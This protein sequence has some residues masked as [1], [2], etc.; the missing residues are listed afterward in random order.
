MKK[1]LILL[2]ILTAG[3]AIFEQKIGSLNNSISQIPV[4]TPTP[5]L[6]SRVPSADGLKNL[7]MKY[8]NLE[9]GSIVYSFYAIDKNGRNSLLIYSKAVAKGSMA[10]PA[11]SWSPGN[12]F[13]FIEDREPGSLDYLVFKSNGESFTSGEKYLDVTKLFTAKV[14]NFTL[15]SVTG[16]DDPVLMSVRASDGTHFWFAIETQNFIQLVR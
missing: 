3:L 5:V 7:V 16:W 4:V 1:T 14:K 12:K 13:L 9:N 8:K 6:S 10:L 11:N 15:K 2:L